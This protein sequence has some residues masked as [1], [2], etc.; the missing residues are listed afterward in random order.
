MNQEKGNLRKLIELVRSGLIWDI[1]MF[2]FGEKKGR[3]L[4]VLKIILVTL[5]DFRRQK[6]GLRAVSLAFFS[7]IAIIPCFALAFS[8][9]NGFGLGEKLEELL[10]QNFSESED[11]IR[12]ILV[13]ANNVIAT[14][15]NGGFGIVSFLYFIWLVFWLMIQVESA[16]NYVL[17]AQRSR[18]MWKRISVYMA[19]AVSLPF[20]VMMFLSTMLLFSQGN[21]LVSLI[22]IPFWDTISGVVSWLLVYVFT[23][24]ALTVMYKFIPSCIVPFSKA[25]RAG[26]ITGIMFILFQAI[27]VATQ[28]F[29][30]RLSGVFGAV[31]AIP[32]MM[33]WL[34]I[35]WFI[36]LIGAKLTYAYINYNEYK[37]QEN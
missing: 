22:N 14:T 30:N 9:S 3:S 20:V 35:A 2:R 10:L 11:V 15:H 32:F 25:F 28:V 21:G 17:K 31:A 27:Y 5:E 7:T 8:V 4:N 18:S 12:Q 16:F 29:F 13:Y 6:V 37:P 26:A 1:D 19:L 23:V 36:V 34:N 33:I 24:L